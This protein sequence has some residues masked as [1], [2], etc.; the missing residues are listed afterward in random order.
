VTDLY[1][2]R[3]ISERIPILGGT[4]LAI[5]LAAHLVRWWIRPSA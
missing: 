1:L 3:S 5:G 4:M 2:P